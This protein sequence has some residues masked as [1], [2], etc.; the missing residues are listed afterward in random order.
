MS[1]QFGHVISENDV[2]CKSI[3][4]ISTLWNVLFFKQLFVKVGIGMCASS[5]SY[6]LICKFGGTG[7]TS[8]LI[9]LLLYVILDENRTKGKS[10]FEHW[11]HF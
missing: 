9:S 8:K 6:L 1:L 10:H 2:T 3:Q 4:S 5:F 11:P 7:T